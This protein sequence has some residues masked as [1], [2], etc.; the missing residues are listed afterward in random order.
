MLI[1]MNK[2]SYL[3]LADIESHFHCLDISFNEESWR[4]NIPS[5]PGWYLIETNTPIDVLKSV[6][7]PKFKAHID[8]PKTIESVSR[9]VELGLAI[10]QTGNEYY[11]VYNGE[12][13]NLNSRAR[14][15]KH[16]HEK[17]FCLGLAEYPAFWK[18]SWRFCFA[19]ISECKGL[20]NADKSVRV[21]F[22]QVWRSK[23]GWPILCKK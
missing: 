17:T 3:F 4:E 1:L 19:S 15:H 9:L 5:E 14:E 16:G 11:V 12:A 23:H 2:E 6:G 20:E 10:T 18:Y 13:Q 8:I 21:L 7:L 22:E